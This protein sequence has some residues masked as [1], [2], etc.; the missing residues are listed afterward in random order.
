MTHQEE[1][2]H[3]AIERLHQRH[4]RHGLVDVAKP[5][6]WND[7]LPVLLLSGF[8]AVTLLASILMRAAGG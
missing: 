1:L 7:Q 8:L 3:R 5:A 6:S 2:R 4:A